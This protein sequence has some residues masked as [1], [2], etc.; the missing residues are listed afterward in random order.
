MPLIKTV[1]F[2]ASKTE[3]FLVYRVLSIND[4]PHRIALSIAIAIFITW[5]PT[6]GLQMILTL[7]LCFLLRA[8]KFV[9][10][11]FVWIS[12][13]FTL[14]PIYAPNY[15]VGCW[16][17]GHAPTGAWKGLIKASTSSTDGWLDRVATSFEAIKPIFFE[18][19]VGSLAVGLVLGVITYFVAYRMIV[20]YRA[21]LKKF[22]EHHPHKRRND[23]DD[24]D[25]ND[26]SQNEASADDTPA[27]EDK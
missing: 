8:N 11:P 21:K 2:I 1:K 20:V 6:I 16:I 22:H 14:V 17:M 27:N 7:A 3:R 25:N 5:T 10:V 18:L 12:N 13:P 4:S 15:W 19:W 24:S 23:R 9:G 26:S